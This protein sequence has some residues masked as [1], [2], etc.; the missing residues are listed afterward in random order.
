M[1]LGITLVGA[2]D[3]VHQNLA[4]PHRL[5]LETLVYG[6]TLNKFGLGAVGLADGAFEASGRYLIHSP[7][8]PSTRCLGMG[9]Y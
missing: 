4:P 8:S 2:A 3:G 6:D 9:P 1:A 7:L 5:N